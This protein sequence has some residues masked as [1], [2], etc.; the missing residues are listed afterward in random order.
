MSD[1]EFPIPPRPKP[2]PGSLPLHEK[3]TDPLEGLDAEARNHSFG[4]GC[5]TALD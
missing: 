3:H 2:R 5:A 4:A 1:I